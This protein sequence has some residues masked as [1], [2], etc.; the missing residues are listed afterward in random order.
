[1]AIFQ[2]PL[3]ANLLFRQLFEGESCTY[4]YLLAD[5]TTKHAVLIDPVDV[6]SARDLAQL[7]ALGLTL[8]YAFNTHMH[9]DHITGT[10]RRAS[11]PR[12]WLPTL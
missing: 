1:M 4:T 11:L 10:G 2:G 6:T 3:P 7:E 5:R 8:T 9:A 12:G